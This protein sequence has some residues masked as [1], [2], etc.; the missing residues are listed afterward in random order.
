[1]EADKTDAETP[2][3]KH[4][5]GQASPLCVPESHPAHYQV[6]FETQCLFE[7]SHSQLVLEAV[8]EELVFEMH[9]VNVDDVYVCT[10]GPRYQ[11]QLLVLISYLS[12]EIVPLFVH[13]LQQILEEFSFVVDPGGLVFYLADSVALWVTYEENVLHSLLFLQ[14]VQWISLVVADL[15]KD[16]RL[17]S[18]DLFFIIVVVYDLNRELIGGLHDVEGQDFAPLR[19]HAVGFLDDLRVLDFFNGFPDV[20]L[21]DLVS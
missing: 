16:E 8:R 10:E 7:W 9:V 2:Y 21:V 11:L 13:G 19:A 1:M 3:R 6:E 4:Y 14:L 20:D 17:L 12:N 15:L 18:E 5:D